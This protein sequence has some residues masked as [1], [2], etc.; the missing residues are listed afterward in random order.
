VNKTEKSGRE[1]FKIPVVVLD[2]MN[3]PAAQDA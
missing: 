3:V 2:A 1:K